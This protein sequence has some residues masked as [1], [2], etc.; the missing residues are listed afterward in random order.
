MVEDHSRRVNNIVVLREFDPSTDCEGVEEVERR[1]EVGPGGEL[2]LFTDLLGDPICRVRHSPAYLMLVAE[3]VG[4]EEEEKEVVGM[5]RGCIKTVT[6]GKKLSRNGKNVTHHNKNDDVLDDTLKPLPVYTKLAYILG[7]RV[8]PSYRRMGIGLKLVHRVEEWF[9]E[10]GAEY[11]Y[12]ATDNDNK[13]SINLFTDKC[14]YSKFRTPAI[15]VNP[16]FAHRVKL[17]SRVHV[18]T[19]SPS[20]AES[21]YRRRFSTTEFFPRDLG[22]VLNQPPSLAFLAVP[23][24]TFTAGT[25]PGSDQFLADPPESWA[26]LSVW[27]CKD[28]Y[29]LE[30]RGASRV[31]RTLAKTTR[32]VDRALPWLRL[33]ARVGVFRSFFLYGLGGSGPRAE[34]FVKALCGHAHN[35]AKERGCGVVATEVSRREPLRLGIP[36]WKRLSCDE[37]LW[38]IKRLGEDYSDGSV[39]DWTKSPPGMSIFVDP[40]EF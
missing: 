11:S 2:S 13:P 34:K 1:C 22:A 38:C 14:G 19:L 33:P 16:V 20:D 23:R 25:W 10:N 6:C 35:L 15:L 12:M 40:R 9:R 24:G 17:S 28:A 32:I 30:V 27:N 37:D 8:S 3:L 7:L 18:I 36:H 5:I 31:K 39:G 26:V 4:E 21:L 29:T